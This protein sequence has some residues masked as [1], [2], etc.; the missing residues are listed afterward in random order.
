MINDY[1]YFY[2]VF[3][4]KFVLCRQENTMEALSP[5][6]YLQGIYAKNWLRTI[7][8][9]INNL[10]S[11]KNFENNKSKDIEMNLS[12]GLKGHPLQFYR[13]P[14]HLLRPQI[15]L[16][17]AH[18]HWVIW[19]RNYPAGCWRQLWHPGTYNT[20]ILHIFL[21]RFVVMGLIEIF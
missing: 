17:P 3:T 18:L 7:F 8:L 12:I 20:Q 9:L 16:R 15:S 1:S 10:H 2:S 19:A 21:N 14:E 5:L 11:L 6:L 4:T 13:R